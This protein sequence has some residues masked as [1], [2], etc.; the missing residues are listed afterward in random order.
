[1]S[2]MNLSQETCHYLEFCEDREGKGFYTSLLVF[3]KGRFF[4]LVRNFN[5][6]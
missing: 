2:R 4:L 1:M 3:S 6:K 5:L